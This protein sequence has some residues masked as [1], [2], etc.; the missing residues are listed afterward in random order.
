MAG[1]PVVFSSTKSPEIKHGQLHGSPG[2]HHMEPPEH[3]L[4]AVDTGTTIRC[5]CCGSLHSSYLTANHRPRQ[6][7]LHSEVSDSGRGEQRD[8][9]GHIKIRQQRNKM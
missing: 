6:A 9:H 3:L 4:V 2:Q 1:L 5:E 8:E 7:G